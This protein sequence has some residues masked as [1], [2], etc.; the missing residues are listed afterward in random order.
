MIPI[1]AN[2][3]PALALATG[4]LLSFVT[5][6]AQVAGTSAIAPQSQ[7]NV[8]SVVQ[9]ITDT[10]T[11][12]SSDEQTPGVR[13]DAI[14]VFGRDVELKAE[15]SAEAV[16]VIGGSARI[17]GRVR[18]SVVVIGGSAVIEGEVREAVVAIMG[19]VRIGPRALVDKDVVSVGG[20]A[21][22]LKGGIVH[23]HVQQVDIALPVFP[24]MKG[25][26][27][28]VK[29]CVME[30]R[31]LAP[32]VRFVWI[33]AG[34]FALIYFLVALAFPRPVQV[35][36]NELT[37]RPAT[38]FLIGLLTKL[39]IPIIVLILAIT[40]IGVFVIP[41]L[42]AAVFFG[43]IIGKV[44]LLEGLGGAIGRAFGLQSTSQPLLAFLIGL[45]VLTLLYMIP[46]FGF[47]VYCVFAI[48]SLGTVTTAAF[49]RMRREK[50]IQPTQPPGFGIPMTAS[51]PYAPVAPMQTTSGA[52]EQPLGSSLSAAVL[53]APPV[54]PPLPA[55]LSH[56]RAGFWERMGAAFLDW[57][58]LCIPIALVGPF[59]FLVALAYFAGMW[60]W[61]GTTI[62]GIVL[63]LQVVRYEGESLNFLVAL[64]RAL[65]AAFSALVLFL[66]FF[67]IGW[68]RDKQGWH[69]RIAGTVVVRLPRSMSLVCL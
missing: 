42:V 6:W 47:V 1:K 25:M 7:T 62:G 67:W 3:F 4:I 19:N 44:A 28:W 69:D 32:Q 48:W 36:V 27:D 5:G 43:V 49:S 13:H 68:D 58:L 31:P 17:Y 35:C 29:Y 30:M 59:I 40:G 34:I 45:V 41:F 11:P 57:A 15:D 50:R 2:P 56:P 21:D 26:G 23:G 61:K 54:Q 10:N 53:T 51:P 37:N 55:A 66:G 14:V 46:I 39:L 9:P 38:T 63:K 64:V 65:A 60:T 33:I 24:K 52:G 22:I 12:P 8:E 20:Q 16:V 18:E